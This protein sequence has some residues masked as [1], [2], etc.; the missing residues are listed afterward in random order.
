M[1]D[2]GTAR[3]K[4]HYRTCS[5]CEAMCGIQIEV[6]ANQ[7]VSIRGDEQDPF[8][9]GYICPKAPALRDLHEDPDRL[10]KPMRK[11]SRGWQ[12]LSWEDALNEAGKGLHR[13]QSN[14]SK[15]ALGVYLGNPTVHN[16]GAILF[17]PMFLRGLRTK[18]RFSATSV[19]Q[20]P[21]MLTSY[22]M[23]GHQ[24]LL[25]I[26]DIDRTDYM[27][28]LGANPMASNGSL[29]SA[30]DIRHRLRAIQNRGGKIVVMD[31]RRSE[32]AELA[33]NHV[34]IRPGTDALFL[35]SFLNILLERGGSLGALD[36]LCTGLDKVKELIKPFTAENT[37]EMTGVGALT[38]QRL[39][40]EFAEAPS[41]V[42]YGRMG[43][44]T[45]AFGTLCQWLINLINIVTGNF[46]R[47]GGAMFTTPA[48]DLIQAP[49]ELGVGRGSF[50]RWKSRVRQLPEF[51]GELPVATLAEEIL[52]EGEDQIRGL[53][54]IAGNPVLS[55]PN[56]RQLET[57]LKSLEFMVSVDFFMNETT[58]QAD[59]IL[60]PTSP[61]EHDHYD[62]VFN[63]LAVRNVAKYS[64]PVLEADPDS[65]HDWQILLELQSRMDSYRTGHVFAGEI[66][67]HA[68]SWLGTKGVLAGALRVGPY[69]LL[70]SPG[71]NLSLNQ[72]LKEPHGVDLGP[73]QPCLPDR[74]PK[75]QSTINLAPEIL[76]NDIERL[77]KNFSFDHPQ[78]I[79]DSKEM[80]LI[81]RRHIRS[82]N[83]W[84]H[85]VPKLVAGKMRCTVKMNH[86]D[87]EALE[88]KDGEQVQV[89]ARIGE[90]VLPV[91]ITDEMMP[92]VVSIPHGFG[93]NRPETKLR[94]AQAHAGVSIND[95][96]DEL[97]I[98]EVSG[99]AAFSG[100]KVVVQKVVQNQLPLQ[101]S[102]QLFSLHHPLHVSC[103]TSQYTSQLGGWEILVELLH[104]RWFDHFS[105]RIARQFCDPNEIPWNFVTS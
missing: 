98:D 73:L 78:P 57:A 91:E 8:S 102:A 65:K 85:N 18:N 49:K 83:S 38:T 76:C 21:H 42:C 58:S 13:V 94:V 20:L 27:L 51:G 31:P 10:R 35:L 55:T 97:M 53:L 60:P 93:H 34:F 9:R 3:S 67:K 103:D 79:S 4:T 54:T 101:E 50:G 24:L 99:N 36:P 15:S 77:K 6:K 17:A 16:L 95:I 5:L 80:F 11:T 32:T 46:D 104:Q 41:A 61:L 72:L 96:T 105:N 30:P 64:L 92:G 88:L 82:N 81:G 63:L 66:K 22:L 84:L 74:L 12:E 47:A 40:K 68:L 87:A 23:F 37:A 1:S 25:P 48:V 7:V 59:I 89:N 44:C 19:D 90:I 56:G 45:Q 2:L 33:G 26:P 100:T 69:G 52:T 86:F 62:V 43:T 28:M 71:T 70:Q 14:H 29:M 75:E 39:A